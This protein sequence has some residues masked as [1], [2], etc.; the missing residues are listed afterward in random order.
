MSRLIIPQSNS[1]LIH[2]TFTG[3]DGT[4]LNGR[5][6]DINLQGT[7]W[8]KDNLWDLEIQSNKLSYTV[9]DNVDVTYK[10]SDHYIE[11]G[12]NGVTIECDLQVVHEDDVVFMDII[13]RYIDPQH[14]ITVQLQV[15]GGVQV[16]ALKSQRGVSTVDLNLDTITSTIYTENKLTIVDDG[17]TI[18]A[19]YGGASVTTTTSEYSSATKVG[20]KCNNFNSQTWDNLKVWK[21]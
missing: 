16:L 1:L 14:L 5:S 12:T 4:I 8:I 19:T 20:V 6:P 17:S 10:E 15:G 2:D 13:P 11:V 3:S 7:T 21:T 9:S 18:T